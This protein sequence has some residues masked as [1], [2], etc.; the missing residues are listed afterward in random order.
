MKRVMSGMHE[1]ERKKL[2]R[3]KTL[4]LKKPPQA[5]NCNRSCCPLT[6]GGRFFIMSRSRKRFPPEYM[7]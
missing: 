1:Y 5:L 3:E 7:V 4:E 6:P 2:F